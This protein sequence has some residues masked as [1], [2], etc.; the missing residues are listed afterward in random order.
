V[1]V[2][3]LEQALH[4]QASGFTDAANGAALDPVAIKQELFPSPAPASVTAAAPTL[5]IV[6]KE[7]PALVAATPQTAMPAQFGGF[8]VPAS[9]ASKLANVVPAGEVDVASVVVMNVHFN[10]TPEDLGVF[11]H[12]RCGSVMRATILKNA[13]GM[14]KGYA[15]MQLTDA[16]AAQRALQLSGAE[17]MGRTLRVRSQIRFSG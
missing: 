7:P 16:N 2:H 15:Y 9:A 6:K 13:H 4:G 11:F 3:R 14:A 12:Q 10:A 1:A 8:A 5:R 17:F